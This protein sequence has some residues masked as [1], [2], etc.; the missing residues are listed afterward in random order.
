MKTLNKFL[1]ELAPIGKL[2]KVIATDSTIRDLVHEGE[3]KYGNEADLNY[4]DV[5]R[6]TNMSTLFTF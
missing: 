4:S 5:S 6:V 1:N 3:M 2:E